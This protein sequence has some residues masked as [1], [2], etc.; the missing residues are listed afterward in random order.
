MSKVIVKTAGICGGRA[1][2]AG[3]RIPVWGIAAL[4]RQGLS[5]E[6]IV[7]RYPRITVRQVVAAKQYADRHWGEIDNDVRENQ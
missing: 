6:Q 5:N 4:V 7:R 2:L 3:T 1:R